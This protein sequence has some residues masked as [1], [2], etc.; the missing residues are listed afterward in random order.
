M[1]ERPA[2][3]TRSRRPPSRFEPLAEG[4]PH[5]LMSTRKA[6]SRDK[7]KKKERNEK[8]KEERKAKKKEK[9]DK[10]KNKALDKNPKRSKGLS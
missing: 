8:K 10:K 3:T 4:E 6:L 2:A 5:Q 9:N 7:K 1:S